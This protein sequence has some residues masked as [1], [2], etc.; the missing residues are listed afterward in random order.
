MHIF[1]TLL[2]CARVQTRRSVLTLLGRGALIALLTSRDVTEADANSLCVSAN[3]RALL[4]LINAYRVANGRKAL[5]MS[6]TVAKAAYAHSRDMAVQNYLSHTSKGTGSTSGQRMTAAGYPSIGQTAYGEIIYRGSGDLGTPQA[7]FNW[8]KNSA[9]H[10][11]RML[12]A[13]YTTAG[14]GRSN[15]NGDSRYTYSTVDFAGKHDSTATS[16]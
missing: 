3:E 6:K 7:A 4:G 15:N 16:C 11:A 2:D 12:D 10:N 8:W 9:G 14:V 1:T 5:K 13:R